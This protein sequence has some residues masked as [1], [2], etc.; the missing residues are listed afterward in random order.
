MDFVSHQCH[1]GIYARD[2][3]VQLQ[4]FHGVVIIPVPV[5][6]IELAWFINDPCY[7]G[8]ILL[9]QL[10]LVGTKHGLVVRTEVLM[11][12]LLVVA[13]AQFVGKP[14]CVVQNIDQELVCGQAP[15]PILFEN[16]GMHGQIRE[17]EIR[18]ST[19]KVRSSRH[20]QLQAVDAMRRELPCLLGKD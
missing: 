17:I 5:V 18:L 19:L 10:L 14:S 4:V 1:S 20:R 12:E 3:F 15:Q 9:T 13:Q 2:I 6:H 7:P 11:T 8:D 16:T